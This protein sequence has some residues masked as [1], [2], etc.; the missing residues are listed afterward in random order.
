MKRRR[1]TSSFNHKLTFN[2]K[3]S[4]S[5]RWLVS[6]LIFPVFAGGLAYG[7]WKEE[8][9]RALQ[10]AAATPSAAG[11]EAATPQA[12]VA[13]P[14]KKVD[15]DYVVKPSDTL[16]SIFTQ[17]KIDVKQV[18]ALLGSAT[19]REKF[20]P[21]RPGDKLTLALENGMLF[22]LD[23][24]ISETEML[25][26]RRTM[27]GFVAKVVA[28]P[29][30]V[31]TVQ[32]RGTLN[33]PVFAAGR[34]VGLTPDMVHQVA[35]EIF[36]WDIDFALD[37]RPGDRFNVVY[38]QKYRNGEYLGDGR[39]VAAEFVNEGETY[40]AIRYTSPDGKID[41]YFTPDGQS[42]RRQFVRAPLDFTR[43][44]ANLNAA[45]RESVISTM[46]SHH[47]VDYSAPIGTA[48]KAAGDGVVRFAGTNGEY[49]NVIIIEHG[50]KTSTLYAHMSAFVRGLQTNQRVK[51][52]EI[53]GYVGN[54][55]AATAPHLHYEYRVNGTHTDP[56]TAATETASVPEA[57]L[58]DFRSKSAALL[59]SL[60][61]PGETVVTALLTN[62]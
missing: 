41:G 62:K 37:I 11:K 57:Y 2:T 44:S 9:V 21:L 43:T 55:G 36:G 10:T 45:G 59:A 19:A 48:V 51:Q 31:K 24:P 60:E 54:T 56:S 16:G 5:R 52:G 28:T 58:D 18:P 23:R 17:L 42:M 27:D 25:S 12:P 49:G 26:I 35:N 4:A 20:R 7:L 61:R 50:A 47:G 30:E 39:I 15:I 1:R 6:T 40:R 33:S 22:G 3:Q 34:A 38:E 14:V 53:I 13:P 32:V 8:P 29:I 46:S